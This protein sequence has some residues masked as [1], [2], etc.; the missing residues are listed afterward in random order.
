MQTSA[1]SPPRPPPRNMEPLHLT[2]PPSPHHPRHSP[3][4]PRPPPPVDQ[5]SKLLRLIVR[6]LRLRL[7]V[8]HPSSSSASAQTMR[9]L[10]Q[11]PTEVDECYRYVTKIVP[12]TFINFPL[13]RQALRNEGYQ[14]HLYVKLYCHSSLSFCLSRSLFSLSLSLSLCRSVQRACEKSSD[15]ERR[16]AVLCSLEWPEHS[17]NYLGF[18]IN[19]NL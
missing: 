7:L 10:S 5:P 4:P 2:H 15:R 16:S 3:S 1:P 8:R 18:N 12:D 9:R 17:G 11:M 13:N 19:G 14:E 6:V